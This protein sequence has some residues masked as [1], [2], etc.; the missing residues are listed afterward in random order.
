MKNLAV[1]ADKC[2]TMSAKGTGR[3]LTRYGR[4]K[5]RSRE[6]KRHSERIPEFLVIASPDDSFNKK[7]PTL[8]HASFICLRDH[9]AVTRQHESV[10][11]CNELR[12]KGE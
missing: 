9:D 4:W 11:G 8:Y 10:H 5:T 1:L 2:P 7:F 12:E 3:R 6:I